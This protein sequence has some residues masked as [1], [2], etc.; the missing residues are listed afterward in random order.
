MMLLP[1]LCHQEAQAETY[2]RLWSV[3]GLC[4]PQL[5]NRADADPRA[6]NRDTTPLKTKDHSYSE[7]KQ[8]KLNMRV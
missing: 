2:S 4:T 5:Y 3:D 8:W 6:N 1:E 7:S